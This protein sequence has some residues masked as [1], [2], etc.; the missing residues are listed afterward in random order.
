[1]SARWPHLKIH[2][3]GKQPRPGR[4]IGHVTALGRDL[5]ALRR[6]ATAAAAYLASGV[7]SEVRH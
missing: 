5:A 4:K 7:S 1:V 3:Y 6:D 2:L